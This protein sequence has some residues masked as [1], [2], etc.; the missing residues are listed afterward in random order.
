[1][2]FEFAVAHLILHVF[3]DLAY[4][5]K[6]E[7]KEGK[8]AEPGVEVVLQRGVGQDGSVSQLQNGYVR[9]RYEHR[10]ERCQQGDDEV[11]DHKEPFVTG[12]I[13]PEQTRHENEQDTD[14]E[15]A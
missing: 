7:R 2:A 11:A 13:E 8:A 5:G 12:R 9:Q 10:R 15:A 3:D 4:P 1:M 14:G 6:Q